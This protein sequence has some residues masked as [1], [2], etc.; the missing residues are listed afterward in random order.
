M[1]SPLTDRYVTATVRD[2]DDEQRAEVERELRTT[3]ED[4]IDGRLEAG[5]TSRPEAERSVLAELGDPVRLAA[6]YSGRPLYLIGP[7]VYPQWRRVMTVLLSTLV[8]LVTAVNL[9]VRLFVDDVATEGI[10]PAVVAA[11]WVGF[12]VA[13]NVVF[14]VTVVFALAERGKVGTGVELEWDPDQLPDD[15][16][17]ERVG[18]GE[19]VATVGFLAAAGLALVWQ[20]TSSPVT[21]GSDPVPVLDPALWSGA[22]PWLLV[23]LAAQAAV[24]VAV[25]RRGAWSR[26]LA[27]A[28]VALDLAFA[29]PVLVLLWAHDLFNPAFVAVL[30]EGGW[31]DAERD[32]T[33][34]TAISVVVVLVWSVVETL[35]H[36]RRAGTPA[37]PGPHERG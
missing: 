26:G 32:L 19:T 16:G 13:V 3:I 18:L 22:L 34:S 28:N 4:M 33:V 35:R 5:A 15:D 7:R 1:T 23:V 20:Q 14:W 8:P 30:V 17:T 9:V 25:Y 29:V 24:A 36:L 10:G 21:S 27:V 31:A 2:L 37:Q 11:L 12:M 6:G